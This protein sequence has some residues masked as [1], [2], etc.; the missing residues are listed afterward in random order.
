M[1]L[2]DNRPPAS[3]EI[4]FIGLHPPA[5]AGCLAE[6]RSSLKPKSIVI[7]LAPKLTLSKLASMLDG[8]NR[9]VRVIP[10]APSIIGEGFN[11]I[12]FSGAFNPDEKAGICEFLSPLGKSPEVDESKLEAYAIVTAMGPT[13]L[14]FQFRE[15]QK[16]AES[17]G[18]SPEEAKRG[19]AEMVA[20]AGECLFESGLTGDEVVDLIPVKPLGEEEANIKAI[21][22]AR[23]EALYSKLKTV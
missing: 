6:I 3:Q 14:W 7:S 19:V 1:A 12:A 5:M 9:I 16:M 22:H 15:L 18:L 13:Y 23:L 2:N 10:N 20:G 17:F 21:Y 4:L 8:F 11:P